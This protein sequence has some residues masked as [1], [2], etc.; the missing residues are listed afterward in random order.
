M[1]PFTNSEGK[2]SRAKITAILTA[3]FAMVNAL[4]L[5]TLSPELIAQINVGLLAMVGFFIRSA[6]D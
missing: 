3:A 4:G 2:V 5:I 1:N 6:V